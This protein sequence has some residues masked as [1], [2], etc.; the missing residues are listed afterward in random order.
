MVTHL[1]HQ[2]SGSKSAAVAWALCVSS[3]LHRVTYLSQADESGSGGDL[4]PFPA[5]NY[6]L[7]CDISLSG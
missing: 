2:C 7:M 6:V 3:L 5:S 4:F 1:V